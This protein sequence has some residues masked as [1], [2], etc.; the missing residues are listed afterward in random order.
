MERMVGVYLPS[1][2]WCSSK[3]TNSSTSCM[4]N[5]NLLHGDGLATYVCI[6]D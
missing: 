2:S 5:M 3:I 4:A 1:L 6:T